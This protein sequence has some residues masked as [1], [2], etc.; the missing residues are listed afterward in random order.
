MQKLFEI[1]VGLFEETMLD[2]KYLVALE[3][4]RIILPISKVTWLEIFTCTL[5]SRKDRVINFNIKVQKF[6]ICLE[7]IGYLILLKPQYPSAALQRLNPETFINEQHNKSDCVT[8]M[9]IIIL[10]KSLLMILLEKEMFLE[11]F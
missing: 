1:G 7:I 6:Q 8:V 3:V 10:Q 9:S 11:K 4:L 5:Y 2:R